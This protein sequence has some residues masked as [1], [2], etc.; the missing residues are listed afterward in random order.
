MKGARRNSAKCHGRI[1][2]RRK[3]TQEAGHASD[4]STFP[5]LNCLA[6]EPW[7]A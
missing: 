1:Y 4:S 3:D 6:G 7:T 2:S 5:S